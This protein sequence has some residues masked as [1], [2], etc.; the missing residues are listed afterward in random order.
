MPSDAA[1]TLH[2]KLKRD[3]GAAV[4]RTGD[5][6]WT[7]TSNL[8]H[9]ILLH[10]QA[11]G[12]LVRVSAGMV[13]DAKP[14]KALLAALND[15]NVVRAF[16]RRILIDGKV[17]VVGEMPISSLRPGDVERLVSTVFCL[18]RLDAEILAAHGGR[19]VTV[20]P[21]GLE[22]DYDRVCESWLDVLAA[23]GTAT[24]RELTV[25]IDEIADCDCWLDVA[26]DS[27]TVVIA[28]TGI[29]SEYPFRL[30]ELREA[31]WELLAQQEEEDE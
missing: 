30:G 2:R 22:P 9:E 24:E 1:A 6:S 8:P 31:A 13:M 27:V 14:T 20:P 18:A 3:L 28:L 21:P 19:L 23:S 25:W 7:T 4:T 11:A 12:P 26:E 29:T 5:H 17:I 10:D 15:L 16:T